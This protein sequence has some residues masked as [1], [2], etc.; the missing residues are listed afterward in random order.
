MTATELQADL[1][2]RG[3]TLTVEGDG[4]R[5]SPWSK[6]TAA[7]RAALRSHKGELL[8]LLLVGDALAVREAND[9]SQVPELCQRQMAA[10]DAIDAAYLAGNALAVREAVR[11]FIALM[12]GP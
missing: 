8:T 6:L 9:W 4:I 7:D 12:S 2:R 5:I 1:T 3:F 11:Q 10:M